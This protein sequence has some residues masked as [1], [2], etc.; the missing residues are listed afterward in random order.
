MAVHKAKKGLDLPITGRPRQELAAAG[1][2]TRVAIMA[3]DYPG[4]KPRM[5][6][7][8]GDEVRR[9]QTLFEDRKNP[10][11]F[12]TSPGA[13]RLSK[14][15]RGA[16]RVLQSV[17]I[18]LSE[19][20]VAGDEANIAHAAFDAFTGKA[21]SE[22]SR[23]EI[24]AL[25]VESGLW[26]ALRTRPYS[27]NPAPESIPFAVF[28]N[29]MDSNAL[30]ASP[31]VV[32]GDRGEQLKAGLE[33]LSKLTEGDTFLCVRAGSSLKAMAPAGVRA[34]EFDGPH[35]SGTTGYHIHTLAPV[36][37]ARVVWSLGY[38]EAMAVAALFQTGKLDMNRVVSL[39]GPPVKDPRLVPTRV[40]ASIDQLVG[41]EADSASHRLISGSVLA[42][43]KAMGDIFGYLGRH[44]IQVAVLGEGNNRDFLGWL[45]PGMNFFSVTGAYISKFLAPRKQYDFTTSTNGSRRAMVP[46]GLYEK[47]MPMDM[48]ATFLLRALAVGDVEEAEKLG[49]LEL[50]EEDLGLCSF[51]CPGKTNY[52]RLLRLNLEIIEKE[53]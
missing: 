45:V 46:I 2:V 8:E 35:P 32:V 26:T 37:R 43:K 24:V 38:Q 49:C 51:V 52:G 17:V 41:D 9:G 6:V 27:R 4:M 7:H 10:G 36:N 12:F 48:M 29:A 14:I 34:E 13:G 22:L 3:D 5:M 21:T 20:E 1:T 11:V 50:D 44:H 23:D 30:G 19:A 39:A 15:N 31:E 40:G 28:V 53:G 42:G 18:E 33:I 25:L 16:R 47:V